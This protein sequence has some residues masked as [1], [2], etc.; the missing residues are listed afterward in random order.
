MSNITPTIHSFDS[1]ED[2]AFFNNLIEKHSN[3]EY[4]DI[5]EVPDNSFGND[6]R[7]YDGDDDFYKFL[8]NKQT[9]DE[10]NQLSVNTNPG[11]FNLNDIKAQNPVKKDTSALKMDEAIKAKENSKNKQQGKFSDDSYFLAFEFIK[12]N[13]LLQIP[14]GIELNAQTLPQILEYDNQKRVD[15]AFDY[16]RGQAGDQHVAEL[17]DMV[18]AGGTL[19][20]LETGKDIVSEEAY[21]R[22]L[23]IRDEDTQR[24][25][26][27][28]YLKQGLDPNIPSQYE[29]LSEI[30]NR[31]DSIIGSYQ[32]ETRAAKALEH[33][34]K[35]VEIG[36]RELQRS[37]TER[38][39]NEEAIKLAKYKREESWRNSFISELKNRNWSNN[40]KN[41]VW[42]HFNNVTLEDG[43]V[44]PLWDFKM[45]KIWENPKHAQALFRF[46]SEFDEYKHEFK[47]PD[48]TPAQLATDKIME[49]AARKS[50]SKN[51]TDH[52]Y[53]R[54][55]KFS[56]EDVGEFI[57]RQ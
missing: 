21:L 41:E 10:N 26:L 13:N 38:I 49:M 5:Q 42:S 57:D 56:R 55:N 2:D 28:T 53:S 33:F 45:K 23:D 54:D 1:S 48:K 37:K 46:L 39:Q 32:G 12:E 20:E 14:E 50:V 9:S 6:L 31:I 17:F 16:I 11:S 47:T 30:P 19:Q 22:S 7:E 43:T 25:L 3:S 18:I 24:R 44:L 29:L 8:K 34:L 40:K 15:Q 35:D 4:T 36:K 27:T 52:T 51:T